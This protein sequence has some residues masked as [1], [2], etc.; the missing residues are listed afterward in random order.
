M[1]ESSKLCP[2]A[3]IVELRLSLKRWVFRCACDP[4]HFHGY[5][6]FVNVR[7]SSNNLRMSSATFGNLRNIFRNPGTLKKIFFAH[8]T[9]EKLAG[10]YTACIY[11]WEWYC[12]NWL[13]HNP[14][15][16]GVV[17]ASLIRLDIFLSFSNPYAVISCVLCSTDKRVRVSHVLV[18]WTERI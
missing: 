9:Q 1:F 2:N 3:F 17:M 6:L 14:S 7:K 4:L 15:E 11:V 5:K 18:L 16:G 12:W 13:M 8:L 10:I